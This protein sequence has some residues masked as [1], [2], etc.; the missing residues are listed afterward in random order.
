MKFAMRLKVSALV[1]TAAYGLTRFAPSRR[2]P[3]ARSWFDVR[4]A[5]NSLGDFSHR[6]DGSGSEVD[7][8][9]NKVLFIAV[10]VFSY[11]QYP[12]TSFAGVEDFGLNECMRSGSCSWVPW[13]FIVGGIGFAALGHSAG[14]RN[15]I[16]SSGDG[17][18]LPHNEKPG[19]PVIFWVLGGGAVF[20]GVTLLI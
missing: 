17:G 12:T 19:T 1:S 5:G 10:V 3:H 11:F 13:M 15:Y 20:A 18:L 7:L 6:G 16:D 8:L 4:L 14:F 9:Q 2:Q